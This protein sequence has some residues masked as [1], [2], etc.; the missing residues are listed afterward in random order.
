MSVLK[1]G[2][3][4]LRKKQSTIVKECKNNNNSS[5]THFLLNKR[6][7]LCIGGGLLLVFVGGMSYGYYLN[8]KHK[9]HFQGPWS[10]L[11]AGAMNIGTFLGICYFKP[12]IV[13]R[14]L[15]K[16]SFGLL[17]NSLLAQA[18]VSGCTLVNGP[19]ARSTTKKY[20]R[21]YRAYYNTTILQ[22]EGKLIRKANLLF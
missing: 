20:W 17:N 8:Y 14:S 11:L 5:Q 9:V 3:D 18:I 12:R 1:R 4:I 22:H 15:N 16:L 19:T 7:V 10:Y 2:V 6:T 13:S 21:A